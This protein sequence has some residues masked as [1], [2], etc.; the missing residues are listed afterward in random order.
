M[1]LKHIAKAIIAIFIGAIFLVKPV[2]AQLNLDEIDD[3][4]RAT[5]VLIAPDLTAP[6][7]AAGQ[8]SEEAGSGVLIARQIDAK[9][10]LESKDPTTYQFYRYWVLT[11]SH[12]VGID[13]DVR[14]GIRTAD[15]EVHPEGGSPDLEKSSRKTYVHKPEIY[16][17]DEACKGGANSCNAGT[18]L[19]VLTFYSDNIYPVAAI[20]NPSE[21][22]PGQ[23]L[24]ASGWPATVSRNSKR[25]RFPANGEIRQILPSGQRLEGNYNLETT[26]R[27]KHGASGGPVFNQKG[28]LIGIYG[29]GQAA[30]QQIGSSKNYAIDVGQFLTLQSRPEY[31]QAFLIAP[32]LLTAPAERDPLVVSFGR[33]YQDIGDNMTAEERKKFAFSDILDDDPAKAAIVLLSDKYGCWKNYQGAHTGAGLP[34][35]RGAFAGDLNG[36]LDILQEYIAVTTADIVN[37]E[38]FKAFQAKVEALE[39]R[40][41]K[42]KTGRSAK[43]PTSD[44]AIASF[45]QPLSGSSELV[46]ASIISFDFRSPGPYS[47]C[48]EDIIQLHLNATGVKERGRRATCLPEV[49]A[50]Y[51]SSGLTRDQA[52]QLIEAA[53]AYATTAFTGI[54]MYPLKGQRVRIAEFFGFMYEIDRSK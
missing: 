52:R 4:A 39:K 54:K 53:N 21:I 12:V 16:R 19:A 33:K 49:F 47:Y 9:K 10:S 41:Q 45:S 32:P 17:F 31:K 46:P 18:D 20:G 34:E 15:G 35:A 30:D 2:L 25:V 26:I 22:I 27:F 37:L 5:T 13:E 23:K 3:I 36:C 50:R 8:E 42:L 11:N 28:E 14:Y 38:G 1:S 24:Q 48:V 40:V 51:Q 29:K 6:Q 44:L 43:A 7:V